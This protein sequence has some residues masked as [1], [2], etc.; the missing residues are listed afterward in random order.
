MPFATICFWGARAIAAYMFPSND[1]D[2]KKQHV[3]RVYHLHEK[4]KR[5]EQEGKACEGPPIWK[6]DTDL[7]S[8]KSLLDAYYRGPIAVTKLEAAEQ[9]KPVPQGIGSY[10]FDPVTGKRLK[11]THQ[12]NEV[13]SAA[14]KLPALKRTE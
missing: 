9:P 10:F 14:E 4:W 12:R 8:R 7:I 3:R 1:A 5:R 11:I 6:Q 13:R 2:Q